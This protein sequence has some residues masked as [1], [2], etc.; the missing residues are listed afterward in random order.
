MS[1]GLWDP[2]RESAV[3]L[4]A[5]ALIKRYVDEDGTQL[6]DEIM[7]PDGPTSFVSWIAIVEA[8]SNFERMV[9]AGRLSAQEA[10]DAARLLTTEMNIGRVFTCAVGPRTTERAR[11]MLRRT[12]HTPA[13]AVHI[14]TAVKLQE[15]HGWLPLVFISA[16]D[17]LIKAA[18]DEFLYVFNPLR[19]T[20]PE[21]RGIKSKFLRSDSTVGYSDE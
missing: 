3:Y 20:N 11:Q 2:W 12:Y 1:I 19:P 13:D 15:Q 6:V 21:I 4:D 9:I 18:S 7:S 8:L 17:K 5:S 10:N 16:D 14:A